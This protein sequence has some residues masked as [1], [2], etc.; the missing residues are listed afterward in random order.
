MNKVG[1]GRFAM[2]LIDRVVLTMVR[3]WCLAYYPRVCGRT[4]RRSRTLPDPARPACYVDKFLW[5]KI[6]DH[7]PLFTTA[8]D[9][10]AAKRYALAMCP[11]LRTAKVLWTGNNPASI[12]EDVL[13]GNVVVKA[14]HG[15]RW[16]IMIRDGRV[17]KL[18]LHSSASLWLKRQYGRSFGEWGYANALRCIF[19]EEM[20][21]QNGQPV[22]SEYK[23]HV[24]GGKT[25][26]IF[27]TRRSER[28]HDELCHLRPDGRPVQPPA[29]YGD[30]WV[31]LEPPASLD[32]MRQ[33]A[34][35]LASRFDHVRC[36]FYE[37]DGEIFFS[38][39]TV[40]SL[41]GQ[42]GDNPGLTDLSNT[43][44]DLRKAWFLTEPQTG[45]RRVY[46]KALRRWLDERALAA[47]PIR[48]GDRLPH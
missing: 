29:G 39:L 7:N 35:T 34:E 28:G 21:L 41:S 14:N 10:L 19:V 48:L 38:E 46:A 20:L 2:Q 9:K 33:F 4:F 5:R 17:D 37:L 13:A 44:W 1:N 16:N 18:T 8:C 45:W 6:F 23:F 36:D 27:V 3:Y 42:I 32:R 22:R 43:A 12:P 24:S 30:T 15:S 47:N 26:Y 31:E 40:Y 25:A 11:G